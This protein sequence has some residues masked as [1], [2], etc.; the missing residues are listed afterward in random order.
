MDSQRRPAD[1]GNRD[2]KA[3]QGIWTPP[4]SVREIFPRMT[5]RKLHQLCTASLLLLSWSGRL[6]FGEVSSDFSQCRRFFYGGTP[7]EGFAAAGYQPICQ[8]YKNQ[9][10]FASLYHL[11]HRIPLYSA[12]LLSP[13]DGKRPNSS[14][15]YEPQVKRKCS[16]RAAVF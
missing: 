5:P 2:L 11:Q 3:H 12:Y 13:A 4:N 15:M 16:S 1:V 6:A 10:R 9:Y 7:P 8:R 14:W